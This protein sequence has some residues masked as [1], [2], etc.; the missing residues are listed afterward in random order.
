MTEKYKDSKERHPSKQVWLWQTGIYKIK[1]DYL[2]LQEHENSYNV[3][4]YPQLYL[5]LSNLNLDNR[6]AIVDFVNNYGLLGIAGWR[7]IVY[8]AE[9][10][11]VILERYDSPKG[12]IMGGTGYV[13]R[14]PSGSKEKY[15]RGDVYSFDLQKIKL[16]KDEAYRLKKNYLKPAI[17]N[18]VFLKKYY[19]GSEDHEDSSDLVK[20]CNSYLPTSEPLEE[21]KIEASKLKT[22]VGLYKAL[23]GECM[24]NIIDSCKEINFNKIPH[25]SI[26]DVAYY[27]LELAIGDFLLGIRLNMLNSKLVYEYE[28]KPSSLLPALYLQLAMDISNSKGIR[29]CKFEDCNNF[30]A[31]T[32]STNTSYCCERCKNLQKQRDYDRLKRKKIK[33]GSREGEHNGKHRRV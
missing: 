15:K 7:Y 3:F 20:M 29:Q 11:S 33:K 2:V 17:K 21:F 16:T 5:K 10:K 26:K 13:R 6:Q 8:S 1:N 4:D 9:F 32:R 12:F 25:N 31:P 30:F 22:I 19:A 27:W 23:Q 14:W 18:E 24:Q 28:S